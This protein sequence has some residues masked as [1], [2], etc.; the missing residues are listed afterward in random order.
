M[1]YKAQRTM[2][3][4]ALYIS[5]H[6]VYKELFTPYSVSR[7]LCFFDSGSMN[8]QRWERIFLLTEWEFS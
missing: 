1:L 5:Q 2:L 7:K 4:F 6:T 3:F 8:P